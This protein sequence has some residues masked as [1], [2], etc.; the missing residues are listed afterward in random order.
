L[1][2]LRQKRRDNHF[3]KKV[4]TTEEEYRDLVR[5]CREEIRKAISQL[6][7]RLTTLVRDNKKKVFCR[8]IGNKKRAKENLHPLLDAGEDIATKDE[9]KAEVLTAF[10]ILVFDSQTSFSM[11]FS[12]QCWKIG[13]ERR[14]NLP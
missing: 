14:I 2:G 13:K 11:V 9:Q 4:Q 8:Y 3:W 1:L 5:P 7:L 10:F 12:P 6:E